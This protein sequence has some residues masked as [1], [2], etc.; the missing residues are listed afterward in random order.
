MSLV[1][2]RLYH[3]GVEFGGTYVQTVGF[4][5]RLRSKSQRCKSTRF[6][7]YQYARHGTVGT[8]KSVKIT[9]SQRYLMRYALVLIL[10]GGTGAFAQDIDMMPPVPQSERAQWRAVGQITRTGQN[11]RGICTGT[12]I[13]PDRVITAAHCVAN[14]AGYPFPPATILFSAGRDGKKAAAKR[15][16]ARVV[17]H[18]AYVVTEGIAKASYDV[19]V[20]WLEKPIRKIQPVPLSSASRFDGPMTVLGYQARNRNILN[21]RSDCRMIDFQPAYF[22]LNCRVISGN[23]GG[24]AL[25]RKDGDWHLVGVVTSKVGHAGGAGL[26][27][28]ARIGQWAVKQRDAVTEQD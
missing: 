6:R 12:L 27:L 10:F 20:I 2:A 1:G 18:P 23:S 21:G 11:S 17:V 4:A 28:V 15:R 19:A 3:E 5:R 14:R 22:G 25:L 16:A 24:P 8:M 13:A 7:L 26:A 9:N